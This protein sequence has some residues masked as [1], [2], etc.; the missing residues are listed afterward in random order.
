MGNYDFL[1]GGRHVAVLGAMLW[2]DYALFGESKRID[3]MKSA[4]VGLNDHNSIG[5]RGTYFYPEHALE[6]H[7][8]SRAWLADEV[9][10]AVND[11]DVAIVVTHHGVVQ[12]ANPPVYRN[13]SLAPAFASDMIDD[14]RQWGCDLEASGHTHHPLDM[15]VGRTRVVSSPRGY[16][17]TE[18]VAER[19]VP[20]VVEL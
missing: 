18:P 12:E 19:Y 11:A 8:R 2:T 16:I 7:R 1:I 5:Y 14:I 6:L 15:V 10:K 9:P 20:L 4:F 13:G 17:G 3:S